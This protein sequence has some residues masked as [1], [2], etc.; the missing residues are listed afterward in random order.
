MKIEA[1]II[2]GLLYDD[3]DF[4]ISE[5]D[6]KTKYYKDFEEKHS[7]YRE[8]FSSLLSPELQT[9]YDSVCEMEDY[10]EAN[11]FELG[12]VVGFTIAMT[13]TA[14]INNPI[15]AHKQLTDSFIPIE[16]AYKLDDESFNKAINEY[17]EKRGTNK[18]KL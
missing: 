16:E 18:C 7:A 10:A 3:S 1:K 11:E 4:G 13:L 8:T 2:R 12:K 14:V 15:G 5:K 17:K 6:Y 9:V